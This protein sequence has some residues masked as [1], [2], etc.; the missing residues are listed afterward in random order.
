MALSVIPSGNRLYEALLREMPDQKVL[1]S[2]AV[3]RAFLRAEKLYGDRTH[4]TGVPLME[5]VIGVLRHMLPFAP[6]ED[7]VVS[8]V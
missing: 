7:A 6:D 8:C 1:R 2:E 4:W 5:H 3:S